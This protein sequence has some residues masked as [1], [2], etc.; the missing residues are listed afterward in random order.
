MLGKI[1]LGNMNSGKYHSPFDKHPLPSNGVTMGGAVES[2]LVL[3]VVVAVSE[4]VLIAL[5]VVTSGVTIVVSEWLVL[6]SDGLIVT[7]LL[8]A[9]LGGTSVTFEM[10]PLD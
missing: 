7:E 8:N 9:L 1:I 4:L 6:F 5:V 10:P 2:V 3:I